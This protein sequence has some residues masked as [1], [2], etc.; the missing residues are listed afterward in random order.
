[1]ELKRRVPINFIWLKGPEDIESTRI[2]VTL[3]AGGETQCGHCLR[4]GAEG[5]P[6]LG[7]AKVGRA[8]MVKRAEIGEYIKGLEEKFQSKTL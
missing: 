4:T 3:G 7:K 8:K 2:T 5:S 6:G 1:M